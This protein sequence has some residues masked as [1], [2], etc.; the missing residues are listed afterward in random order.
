M[1]GTTVENMTKNTYVNVT[2]TTVKRWRI[3]I[4]VKSVNAGAVMTKCRE[5]IIQYLEGSTVEELL[6]SENTKRIKINW[7]KRGGGHRFETPF[8]LQ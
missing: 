4:K 3:R 7:S 2:V 1:I 5:K 6:T 8:F